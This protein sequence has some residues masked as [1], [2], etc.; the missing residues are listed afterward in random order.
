VTTAAVLIIG[1]E[2]LSGR[3]Q[4]Q[5]LSYLAGKLAE[6][7]IEVMEARV[8]SDHEPAIIAALHALRSAARH[9][10]T[11]GGIGPTHDDIT[12]A[13][14]AKAF[15]R[16]LRE[17]P[18]AL[19]ALEDYYGPENLN[20]AR[21]RMALIPEGARLIENPV[22]G[23]P[24]FVLENVHVLAG[25]PRICQAMMDGLAPTLQGGPPLLSRTV[26]AARPE[27]ML[28]QGLAEIQNAFPMLSL[29]SYP[30]W[31][32][33]HPAVSLVARGRDE[34]ALAACAEALQTLAAS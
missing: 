21:R 27:S 4:D 5:N 30:F 23:A 15:G 12:S 16:T 3:T 17:H 13:A 8:V 33:G 14:V 28:A 31:K 19:A 1:N 10:F 22:S 24:G 20:D 6:T 25:V 11:T 26:T 29:G 18:Q 9:V 32:D 2:I 34:N 7:G